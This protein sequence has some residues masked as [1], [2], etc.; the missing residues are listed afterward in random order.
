LPARFIGLAGAEFDISGQG[1]QQIL[2][3][4]KRLPAKGRTGRGDRGAVGQP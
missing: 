4:G 3:L 1:S 2:Q